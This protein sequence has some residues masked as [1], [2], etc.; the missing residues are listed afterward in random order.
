MTLDGQDLD[1]LIKRLHLANARRVWRD[2]T[3]RAEAPS[4]GAAGDLS[5]WCVVAVS[6]TTWPTAGRRR[7][8]WRF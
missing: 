4:S 8:M 6:T 1:A 7:S 3:R 2:L 5:Q